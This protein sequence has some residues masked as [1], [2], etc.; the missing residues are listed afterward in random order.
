MFLTEN[1]FVNVQL[2]FSYKNTVV[3]VQ[4]YL[5]HKYNCVPYF[6]ICIT[7]IFPPTSIEALKMD[8]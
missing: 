7:W 2:H 3:N 5:D 1:T 6:Y 8:D 4:L